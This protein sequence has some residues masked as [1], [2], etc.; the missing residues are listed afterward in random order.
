MPDLSTVSNETVAR[1]DTSGSARTAVHFP[2]SMSCETTVLTGTSGAFWYKPANTRACL[3]A[4]AFPSTGANIT[5]GDF[6]G[7]LVDDPITLAYPAGA[8]TTN[9]IPA[10]DYFVKTYDPTTGIM[11]VSSTVGGAA[12]TATAAPSNFGSGL[13]TIAYKAFGPVAQVREWGL[14]VTRAEIDVTTIGVPNSQFAPFRKYQTSFAD[15]TGNTTVYFTDGDAA[16]SNRLITDVLQRRQ[17]G[18]AVKLYI[19]AVYSGGS[20]SETL[21]RS[22]SCDIVMTSASFAINPDDAQSVAVNFRPS[23]NVTF[24]LTRAS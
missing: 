1:I 24:D 21:S 5:V 16:M 17:T 4:S 8:T 6:Y 22:I 10:G 23:G 7:F 12:V 11:T 2:R 14:E 13:A 3:S 19:D 20:L 18:A 15:A 9:A